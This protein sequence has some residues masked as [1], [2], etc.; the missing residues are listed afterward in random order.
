MKEY[1]RLTRL[2]HIRWSTLLFAPRRPAVYLA[3]ALVPT[4]L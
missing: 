2:L 1:I 3:I 4:L